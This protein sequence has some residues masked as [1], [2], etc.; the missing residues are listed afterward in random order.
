MSLP[1][2]MLTGRFGRCSL[3][4]ATTMYGLWSG[5]AFAWLRFNLTWYL[6]LLYLVLRPE[7]IEW[8]GVGYLALLYNRHLHGKSSMGLSMGF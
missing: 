7:G 8:D 4:H 6:N 2:A 3:E 1:T 5:L